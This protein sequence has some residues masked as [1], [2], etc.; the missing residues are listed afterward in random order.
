MKSDVSLVSCLTRKRKKIE[1]EDEKSKKKKKS[2][3]IQS[4]EE[5]DE[6]RKR[7]K[8][9]PEKGEKRKRRK[10][11]G[12]PLNSKE[13]MINLLADFRLGRFPN[14][15]KLKKKK[16]T[17]SFYITHGDGPFQKGKINEG[18]TVDIS[19]LL[20]TQ[21]RDYLI[22]YKDREHPV[23][24]KDL[25]GKVIVLHFVPLG[26]WCESYMTN[27]TTIL[28]DIYRDLQRK[29]GFE[30]VFVG[31]EVDY[32][33]EP[34]PDCIG[35]IFSTL[36]DCFEYKFSSMPWTAIPFCDIKSRKFLETRFPLS[37]FLS[38]D[39]LAS[40]VIDPTGKVLHTYANTIFESY[41][42][43]AYPFTHERMKCMIS[44][45]YE[46]RKHPSVMKLLASLERN[47]LIDMNNQ[48]V[49]LHDLE[50]KVVGLYFCNGD[51]H[52]LTETILKAYKQLAKVKN[53]EIVLVYFH[54]SFSSGF[55]HTSEESYWKCFREMPWLALPYKDPVCNTLLQVF[56]YP[57][58]ADPDGSEP[59]P[60]LLII[61]PKG[62]FVE[63]YGAD[64]LL[65]YGIS[66][67]P[68][69]R[70]KV[71]KLEAKTMRKNKL[72][73]GGNKSIPL[74]RKDGSIV[75]FSQLMGKRIMLIAE[76][77]LGSNNPDAKFW[78]MLRAR[79]LQMK[80]TSDEFEVIHICTKE[81][82]SYGKNIATTSWLTLPANCKSMLGYYINVGGLFAF[83]RNG[84]LVRR[85]RFPS[86][87]SENMDFPFHSG[88]WKEE[89]RDIIG[90]YQWY[91]Y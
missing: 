81:G 33:P 40:V 50:D 39:D 62:K 28:L 83:D 54:D 82:Y 55:Q 5:G 88:V 2:I 69:T 61:G 17:R 47:F 64:I 60:N 23:K 15:K 25:K 76:I 18:D 58:Y 65:K 34:D 90:R 87:E 49:P 46:A 13:D 29:G 14:R 77:G 20:F 3:Q 37:G 53:F 26:P 66:A 32:F 56:D 68:F 79:Y 84:S 7:K 67:Y 1:C 91:S 41:G 42:A 51:D 4:L 78:R 63:R 12:T 71:A 31:V 80:A 30:V 73:N 11:H 8:I 85:T 10:H 38:F 44:E 74:V 89:L 75:Q 22:T 27:D 52:H 57:N 24:A 48:A 86:I 43:R 9:Q 36:E 59:N 35:K 6:S 72:F 16:K 70:K 21:E 19:E 45:I